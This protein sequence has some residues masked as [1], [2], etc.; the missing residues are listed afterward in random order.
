MAYENGID[1]LA[2]DTTIR[3]L[4]D[5]VEQRAPDLVLCFG[6][7]HIVSEKVLNIPRFGGWG[8]HP[9]K[10]PSKSRGRHPII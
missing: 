4:A 6:W 1:Y 9:A 3:R 10:I 2:Y 8:Y 5:W 7:S